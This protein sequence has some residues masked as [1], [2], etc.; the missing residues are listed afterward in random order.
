M[1]DNARQRKRE[2]ERQEEKKR[3]RMRAKEAEKERQHECFNPHQV[4]KEYMPSSVTLSEIKG[5]VRSI[6]PAVSENASILT[7]V[8]RKVPAKAPLGTAL[9][10]KRKKTLPCVFPFLAILKGIGDS[11]SERVDAS[12]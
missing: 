8:M 5:S 9:R 7:T 11:L 4:A 12:V 3:D 10:E 6:Q 1:K 2:R